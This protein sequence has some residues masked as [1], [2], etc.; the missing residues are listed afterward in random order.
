MSWTVTMNLDRDKSTATV[1]VGSIQA[2]W[3]VID[4]TGPEPVT[5]EYFA[6][7]ERISGNTVAD[8]QDFADRALAEKVKYVAKKVLE[9]NIVAIAIARLNA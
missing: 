5:T 4:D 9:D 7:P 6:Y 1:K 3:E 8:V 2:V